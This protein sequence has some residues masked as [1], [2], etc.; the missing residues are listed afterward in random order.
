MHLRLSKFYIMMNEDI[1][2]KLLMILISLLVFSNTKSIHTNESMNS[3]FSPVGIWMEQSFKDTITFNQNN[4]FKYSINKEFC[5]ARLK[6]I[7]GIYKFH[8]NIVK[9][10]VDSTVEKRL[11]FYK[12]L[13]DSNYVYDWRLKDFKNETFNQK[14]IPRQLPY[15]LI[16]ND[17]IEIDGTLLV[18]IS[19][20]STIQIEVQNKRNQNLDIQNKGILEKKI[21]KKDLYGLWQRDKDYL[22]AAAGYCFA[23]YSDGTFEYF[24]NS[25][26]SW[27]RI[28]VISGIYKL[29]GNVLLTK[30]ISTFEYRNGYNYGAKSFSELLPLFSLNYYDESKYINTTIYERCEKIDLQNQQWYKWSINKVDSTSKALKIGQKLFYFVRQVQGKKFSES[31]L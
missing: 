3:L 26:L 10:I 28:Y 20:T 31:E 21:I 9:I 8:N 17:S 13:G 11:G 24:P 30:P 23:F 5:W 22:S 4:T 6:S 15:L 1:P 29:S 12:G 25:Y 18:R 2:M 16:S 14:T 19:D 7:Y 27:R